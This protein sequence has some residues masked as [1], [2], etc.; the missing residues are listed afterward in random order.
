MTKTVVPTK[1]IPSKDYTNKAWC[2]KDILINLLADTLSFLELMAPDKE[3][4]K[5]NEWFALTHTRIVSNLTP[6]FMEHI[7]AVAKYLRS[8]SNG[9][10]EFSAEDW[11]SLEKIL[12]PNFDPNTSESI[13]K[14]IKR[15]KTTAN[16]E[17]PNDIMAIAIVDLVLGLQLSNYL[18]AFKHPENEQTKK[19]NAIIKSTIEALSSTLAL[20]STPF[21]ILKSD[22]LHYIK[23]D[24]ANSISSVELQF[25]SISN[26]FQAICSQL[27]S[28][29]VQNHAKLKIAELHVSAR[30]LL[31]SVEK[32]KSELYKT[33]GELKFNQTLAELAQVKVELAALKKT[34]EATINSLTTQT[35][36]LINKPAI[37]KQQ[38]ILV[39]SMS[40]YE[41]D[42]QN[43]RSIALNQSNPEKKDKP[44]VSLSVGDFLQF[45]KWHVL[46]TGVYA[47]TNKPSK[48]THVSELIDRVIQDH[49]LT[50]NKRHN[51]FGRNLSAKHKA[52][53]DIYLSKINIIRKD[54]TLTEAEKLQKF[55]TETKSYMNSLSTKKS[56]RYLSNMRSIFGMKVAHGKKELK[57]MWKDGNKGLDEAITNKMSNKGL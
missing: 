46:Y 33:A 39:Q 24:G 23:E 27:P 4:Q 7:G 38:T 43:T 28:L 2:P 15:Y 40:A 37:E 22:E 55:T 50:S 41:T 10:M 13:D 52:L 34:S 42:K 56:V 12:L 3:Q 20:A 25:T 47:K 36:T 53:K 57:A 11:A 9:W 14:R 6:E 26:A 51:F 54:R 21:A 31:L 19:F 8:E 48:I 17:K 16:S 18:D 1:K 5:A 49:K 32:Y 35:T 45:N 29:K 44:A 30:G